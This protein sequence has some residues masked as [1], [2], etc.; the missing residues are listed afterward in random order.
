MV[1]TEDVQMYLG[2]L[3]PVVGFVLV[4][5]SVPDPVGEIVP[6]AAYDASLGGVHF[7]SWFLVS[8]FCLYVPD[9]VRAH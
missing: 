4:S 1:Y 7:Q 3:G 6:V 8:V 9:T 2:C 5:M